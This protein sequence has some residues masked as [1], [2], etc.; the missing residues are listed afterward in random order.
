MFILVVLSRRQPAGKK[1]ST[2]CLDK[3]E[4]ALKAK[5][6]APDADKAP[7]QAVKCRPVPA[8]RRLPRP[9]PGAARAAPDAGK[10]AGAAAAAAAVVA[11]DP[12]DFTQ[13]VHP[14]GNHP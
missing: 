4:P 13:S 1:R 2:P 14:L 10:A 12:A 5:A 3:M 7:V 6:P 11:A 8:R 9:A